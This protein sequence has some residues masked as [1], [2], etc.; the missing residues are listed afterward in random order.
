METGQTLL[1]LSFEKKEGG[2]F[3]LAWILTKQDG[4]EVQR[5]QYAVKTIEVVERV[6]PDAYYS[7]YVVRVFNR[8][9]SLFEPIWVA[10]N[11]VDINEIAH[12]LG[13][14]LDSMSEVVLLDSLAKERGVKGGASLEQLRQMMC[15][16]KGGGHFSNIRQA[17]AVRDCYFQLISR[18]LSIGSLVKEVIGHSGKKVLDLWRRKPLR[19]EGQSVFEKGETTSS[20]YEQKGCFQEF[21]D[22]LMA[23]MTLLILIPFIMA[24]FAIIFWIIEWAISLFH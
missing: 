2:S 16:E 23:A 13:M 9:V 6:N 24:L 20:E 17:E 5:S 4:V 12:Y 22:I 8:T 21:W 1:F 7:Y 3:E 18:N 10:F 11:H 15:P 14:R 19:E